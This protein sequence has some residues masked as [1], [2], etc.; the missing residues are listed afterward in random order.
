MSENFN[1]NIGLE[2]DPKTQAELEKMSEEFQSSVTS[3]HEGLKEQISSLRSRM[4]S[5][6][7]EESGDDGFI[8][9]ATQSTF[10]TDVLSTALGFG[11]GKFIYS[12]VERL[13]DSLD[14][15]AEIMR[16]QIDNLRPFSPSI[17]KAEALQEVALTRQAI[18]SSRLLS[19]ELSAFIDAQTRAEMANR[20][21]NS[22]L[23]QN[24]GNIQTALSDLITA[25]KLSI[26]S[27]VE[28]FIQSFMNTVDPVI[29]PIVKWLREYFDNLSKALDKHLN[30]PG[31]KDNEWLETE[32]DN[33]FRSNPFG[34]P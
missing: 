3:M 23:T 34:T 25:L 15:L 28:T 9:R 20:R 31:P 1:V 2:T 24:F 5:L 27:A 18:E 32:I 8:P 22:M 19:D 33:L 13:I 4:D 7:S 17:Q 6:P 16:S 26:S 21:I 29:Q 11:L 10:A 30:R 14:R 12:T